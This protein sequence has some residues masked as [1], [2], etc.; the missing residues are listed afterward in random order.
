MT[1]A[2]IS[3]VVVFALLPASPGEPAPA[4]HLPS[5]A[6]TTSVAVDKVVPS[7]EERDLPVIV[8]LLLPFLS[9]LLGQVC[10]PDVTPIGHV[11]GML[12]GL[13]LSTLQDWPG[14]HLGYWAASSTAA[15]LLLSLPSLVAAG[16]LPPS[17]LCRAHP[18][19]WAGPDAAAIA[20]ILARGADREAAGEDEARA[21]VGRPPVTEGEGRPTRLPLLLARPAAA[22]GQDAGALPTTIVGR[23]P[24]EDSDEEVVEEEGEQ[25]GGASP[26]LTWGTTWHVPRPEGGSIQVF[27]VPASTST[28]SWG[29]SP[30]PRPVA[31]RPTGEG[32]AAPRRHW[33]DASGQGDVEESPLL[34]SQRHGAT[35]TDHCATGA[36]GVA[37]LAATLGEVH[38]GDLEAGDGEPLPLE[39]QGSRGG[40]GTPRVRGVQGPPP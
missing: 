13:A 19:T 23:A 22:P 5:Q 11:G 35:G 8:L 27:R 29:L 28:A 6:N 26:S 30:P 38:L 25:G 32:A 24:P 20:G 39:E 9:A 16:S 18:E 17:C 1:G 14:L 4:A 34:S 2:L 15:L 21:V 10:V 3:V 33:P 36:G 37:G 12:A 40:T 31:Q 7:A